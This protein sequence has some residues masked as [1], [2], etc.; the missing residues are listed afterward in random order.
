M[1]T[2]GRPKGE[3]SGVRKHEGCLISTHGRPKGESSAGGGMTL[4][5]ESP[6]NVEPSLRGRT[7][8]VVGRLTPSVFSFLYPATQSIG[9]TGAPQTVI[10]ID[11]SVGR[12]HLRELRPDIAVISVPDQAS[13]WARSRA[14]YH[15]LAEVA[16]C[17]RIAAL[18]LHGILPGLAGAR[19]VR[20]FDDSAMQVYMS[21]YSSRALTSH[22]LLRP[23]LLGLVRVQL[24]RSR[25]QPIVNLKLDARLM[26]SLASQPV[27]VVESAAADVF[28]STPRN[29]ARRPL[30]LAG[31]RDESVLPAARFIQLAVLLGDDDLAMSFN[32]IGTAHPTTENAFRAAGIGHFRP[33]SAAERAQRLGTAWLWISPQEEERGFPIGL[34]EAMASGVPCVAQDTEAHRDVLDDTGAGFLCTSPTEMMQRVAELVDSSELRQRMG[35]AGRAAATARFSEAE[36]SRRLLQAYA[37]APSAL[38]SSASVPDTSPAAPEADA[39]LSIEKSSS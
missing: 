31:G 11:D 6:R 39:A 33:T 35:D 14:L 1:S 4:L 18:H 8:H 10:A 19:F 32:W 7:V 24:R 20:Q 26:K 15:Y 21:P 13:P 17:T 3:C 34:V 16:R 30:L 37:P 22:H 5:F 25:Q 23:L 12:E 2:H 28:F 36:F 9:A 29:E 38:I 27:R